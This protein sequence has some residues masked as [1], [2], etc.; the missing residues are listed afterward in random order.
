MFQE[1]ILCNDKGLH[2]VNDKIRS[3]E[4]QRRDDRLDIR[5][6]IKLSED[7]TNALAIAKSVYYSQIEAK[8]NDPN[9]AL[10]VAF[11]V[12]C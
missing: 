11:K 9:I 7:V 2:Q 1:T 8:L 12:I 3:F 10:F 4:T 5:I 6:L